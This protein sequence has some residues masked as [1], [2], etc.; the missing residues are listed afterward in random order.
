MDSSSPGFKIVSFYTPD[1]TEVAQRLINTCNALGLQHQIEAVPPKG[2]WVQGCAF[3]PKFVREMWENSTTPIVWVDADAMIRKAP[4][5]FS[6][7]TADIG[8]HF[9]CDKRYK[10]ELLSG[11]VFFNKTEGAWKIINEWVKHQSEQIDTWDQRTLQQTVESL[12]NI[13]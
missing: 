9:R 8:V 6:Q 5:L 13:W 4:I 7:I 10:N 3:K 11:T 12:E 2:S 1:Y